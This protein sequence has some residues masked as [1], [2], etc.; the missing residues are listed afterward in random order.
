MGNDDIIEVE[1]ITSG[2][3]WLSMSMPWEADN[4][5]L[6]YIAGINRVNTISKLGYELKE[7][8]MLGYDGYSAGNCFVGERG[9]GVMMQ[10]TGHHADGAFQALYRADARV[11]RIDLQVTVKYKTMPDYIAKEAYNDAISANNRLPSHRRRK[12][13]IILGSDGGDTIY[14]GAPSSDQRGRIYNKQVQS[15][16]PEYIRTWRFECVYRNLQGSVVAAYLAGRVGSHTTTIRD[17]VAA[18]YG[19]RGIDCSDFTTGGINPIPIQRTIPTDVEAKLKWLNTQ[20][21]PTVKY[22]IEIGL[23]GELSEALAINIAREEA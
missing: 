2:V 22:L 12:I 13:Y 10:F 19:K 21:R 16:D 3:D 6:W 7:R 11:P 20:V 1:E 14:V 4:M 8:S 18:W 9:D 15:E 23:I 5:Q 17:I